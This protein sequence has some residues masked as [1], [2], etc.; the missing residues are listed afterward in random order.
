MHPVVL[1]VQNPVVGAILLPA[2]LSRE[3]GKSELGV[4]RETFQGVRLCV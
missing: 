4:C 1:N 3:E 2:V